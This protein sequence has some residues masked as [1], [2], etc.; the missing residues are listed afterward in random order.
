MKIK[1]IQYNIENF[2]S[3]IPGLF[4]YIEDGNLYDGANSSQGCYDKY[5]CDI[6][7]PKED[8][9]IPFIQE[10]YFGN[11]QFEN[12]QVDNNFNHTITIPVFVNNKNILCC[13]KDKYYSYRTLIDIYH[14]YKV[15]KNIVK[16]KYYKRYNNDEIINKINNII[17]FLNFID[18]GIGYYSIDI[19]INEYNKEKPFE[20][21][22]FDEEKEYLVPS[23]IYI[24]TA[25]STYEQMRYLEQSC[26]IYESVKQSNSEK[27]SDYSEFCCNCEKFK[28][29][30]GEK[31][32]KL[33]EYCSSKA[34]EIAEEYKTYTN[35][36]LNFEMNLMLMSSSKDMG[37]FTQNR[38]IWEPG[39]EY[40]RGETVFYNGETYLCLGNG[41]YKLC[42]IRRENLFV[43]KNINEKDNVIGYYYDIS[44][45]EKIYNENGEEI[46]KMLFTNNIVNCDKEG[47]I[48]KPSTGFYDEE[49][50]IIRFPYN[51]GGENHFIKMKDIKGDISNNIIHNYNNEILLK[52]I[53]GGNKFTNNKKIYDENGNILDYNHYYYD[54]SDYEKIYN[55]NGEEID[56]MLFTNNIVNCDKEGFVIDLDYKTQLY[57]SMNNRLTIITDYYYE[58]INEDGIRSKIECNEVG[59]VDV[60]FLKGK[61]SSRLR[62]LRRFKTFIENGVEQHPDKTYD[63]LFFYRVGLVRN[64][65]MVDEIGNI[66]KI[67]NDLTESNNYHIYGDIISSIDIIKDGEILDKVV[68]ITNENK[69]EIEEENSDYQISFNYVINGHIK[70]NNITTNTD[71]DGNII[72]I[73]NDFDLDESNNGLYHG[74][75]FN[76]TYNVARGS[77]LENLIK[78][79]DYFLIHKNFK[80]NAVI[81]NKQELSNDKILD[82]FYI[83]MTELSVMDGYIKPDNDNESPFCRCYFSFNDYIN[84]PYLKYKITKIYD[85]D[86]YQKNVDYEIKLKI[87]D[88]KKYEFSTLKNIDN[89]T[90]K[91]SRGDILIE[92]LVSNFTTNIDY[93][94]DYEYNNLYK[95]EYLLGV[96]YQPF[97]K[98]EMNIDRGNGAVYEKYFKM[99]EVRTM[100]DLENYQNGGYFKIEKM[101]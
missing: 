91:T 70:V 83:S 51:I 59:I 8:L 78:Y 56:K 63:W 34:E 49:Y 66:V 67:N 44:D 18:R 6:H 79:G 81:V 42:N 39:K 27:L 17:E 97:V 33:L 20:K 72:E 62:S 35:T 24:A 43:Y 85:I 69:T 47:N 10:D 5:V 9:C 76:E 89:Y 3:R 12:I 82:E 99:M 92:D 4:T 22:Q 28:A 64:T 16:Q 74:I 93:Y 37:L 13:G 96:H 75:N 19:L 60:P 36:K 52:N 71:S 87:P 25:Y 61:T 45:Y 40:Y 55:E 31:M 46:D 98:H 65:K 2:K 7:I 29:M 100:Q 26:D 30:G 48:Y 80:T 73:Y 88:S 32:L 90:I 54:I 57:D 50:N 77:D 86:G 14:K 53:L 1:Q 15:I 41:T 23:G 84:G 11:L 95:E 68:N 94:V 58:T 101:N 21:I 38:Q